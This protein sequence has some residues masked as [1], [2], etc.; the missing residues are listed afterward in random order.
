MWSNFQDAQVRRKKTWSEAHK[1]TIALI[2][3]AS[4][5][6]PKKNYE[7]THSRI[8]EFLMHRRT[9]KKGKDKQ[10]MFINKIF[11]LSEHE[12]LIFKFLVETLLS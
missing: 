5:G 11:M 8:F 2:S 10:E 12:E 6:Y 9:R 3:G 7:K 1:N 4:I